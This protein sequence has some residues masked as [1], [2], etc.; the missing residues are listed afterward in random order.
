MPTRDR[1]PFVE[2]SLA[3]FARQDY[4][5]LELIIIDEGSDPVRDLLPADPR[6]RY[7][8]LRKP[9]NMGDKRNLA[10]EM[11][12]GS[13]IAEW[14]DDDWYGPQRISQQVAPL[15]ERGADI[16]GLTACF[17]DLERWQGWTCSPDLHRQ[18]FLRDV[19]GGTLVFW[20]WVWKRLGPYPSV[21]VAEDAIFLDA[22]CRQGALLHKLPNRGS[23]VYLRHAHNTWRFTVGEHLD[24]QAWQALNVEELIPAEDCAFYQ[25]YR[26]VRRAARR[27][28]LPRT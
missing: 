21:S 20:R 11:A 10:C 6:I 22:V 26:G 28:A 24:P 7:R 12:R 18:M 27:A 14:D 3:Y 15:L 9:L 5:N 13:I 16:S 2:R 8:Y 25:H 17:F 23:F 4:P 1:R 19:H